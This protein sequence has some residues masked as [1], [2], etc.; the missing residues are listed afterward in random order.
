M[1]AAIRTFLHSRRGEVPD[2]LDLADP[3]HQSLLTDLADGLLA[4]DRS[5]DELAESA[6]E[7][8][9]EQG[10]PRKERETFGVALKL[11][12]SRS[13]LLRREH[14][15]R[16]TIVFAMYKEHNRIR[17]RA[18]HPHG[19][20]AI[21]QKVSQ[22]EW[23]TRG[24]RTSWRLL[25][26][27][28]GCPCHSGA[29]V[30]QIFAELALGERGR[31]LFLEDAI[32][33]GRVPTR[34]PLNSTTDSQKGASVLL[35]LWMAAQEGQDDHVVVFTDTDLSTHLGQ[36]GLLMYPILEEGRQVAIGSRR[37]VTS[38]VRKSASR[39]GRGNLFI[40]LWK[41]LLP[42]LAEVVDTQC[43][44]KAF[45]AGILR[46]IVPDAHE[47]RF[48]FDIELLLRAQLLRAGSIAVVPIGWIDS[49]AESTTKD[50]QPYL[51]MLRS[52]VDFY[53]SY[54]PVTLEG[55]A[56]ASLIDDLDEG[57]WQRLLERIPAAILDR[58]PAVFAEWTGVT[59][60]DLRKA[61]AGSG[62]SGGLVGS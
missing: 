28:D 5:K 29:L 36:A 39:S 38:I 13:E 52:T 14:P 21:R 31:V 53:R 27:D 30:E 35:G 10:H 19:E 2:Q 43:G 44:F 3:E 34:T 18:E 22:L 37:E 32:R 11:A 56:F 26:V 46:H 15:S 6:R 51:S 59:A 17:P 45:D 20:D 49:E 41:R 54:A 55:D 61:A 16:L 60:D 47:G 12:Q 48:A 40:Y 23:L 24:T 8:A 50:L 57:S 58:E 9:V 25:A 7:F 1:S 4:L 42:A 33:E 62:P